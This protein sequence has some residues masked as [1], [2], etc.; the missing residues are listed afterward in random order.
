MQPIEWL[1]LI[2]CSL[3]GVMLGGLL[4]MDFAEWLSKTKWYKKYFSI[5]G[6]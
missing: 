2:M 5:Y 6:G 4:I 3:L 1:L